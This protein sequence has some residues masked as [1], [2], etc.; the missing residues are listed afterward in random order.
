MMLD[1]NICSQCGEPLTLEMERQDC[2]CVDCAAEA[3]R[4]SESLCQE[5]RNCA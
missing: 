2:I 1:P 3:A 4:E 5:E